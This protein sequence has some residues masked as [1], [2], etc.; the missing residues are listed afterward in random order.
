MSLRI[1]L[2]PTVL[3]TA[4]G[5]APLLDVS[6]TNI[7]AVTQVSPG[8]T[9]LNDAGAV[10][11]VQLDCLW[12]YNRAGRMT[13]SR[14]PLRLLRGYKV[15]PYSMQVE[16]LTKEVTCSQNHSEFGEKAPTLEHGETSGVGS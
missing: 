3:P 11:S 6:P 12:S 14:L 13:E 5:I 9:I 16:K 4:Q 10:V 1:L 2:P 8:H 7:V 15:I